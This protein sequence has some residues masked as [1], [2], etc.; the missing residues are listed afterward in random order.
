MYI[1]ILPNDNLDE[2]VMATF[3]E[4][5]DQRKISRIKMW[6]KQEWQ[7]CAICGFNDDEICSASTV[8]IEESGDG[9]AMLVVG[10]NQGLRIARI[11]DEHAAI[12]EWNVDN[13]QQWSEGFLICTMEM[14]AR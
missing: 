7:W 1:D 11:A 9:D 6:L 13:D 10:G 3:S 5:G 14:D 8:Q 4:K 2:A 12:P